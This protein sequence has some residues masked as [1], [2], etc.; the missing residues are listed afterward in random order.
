[1]AKLSLLE[2]NR[3]REIV[4]QSNDHFD[5]KITQSTGAMVTSGGRPGVGDR[6]G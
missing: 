5:V 6:D 1:M 2:V 3:H 4:S